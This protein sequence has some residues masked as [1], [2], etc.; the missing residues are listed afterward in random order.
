MKKAILSVLIVLF[1]IFSY[2][3]SLTL[4]NP[5][6][7]IDG[8]STD[9]VYI[10]LQIQNTGSGEMSVVAKRYIIHLPQ[11]QQSYFCFSSGCYAPVVSISPDNVYL[12]PSNTDDTFKGYINPKETEGTSV[13]KYC[14]VDQISGSDSVCITLTTNISSSVGIVNNSHKSFIKAYPNPAADQLTVLFNTEKIYSNASIIIRDLSGRIVSEEFV[15]SA[16]GLVEINTSGLSNGLYFA[17]LSIDGQA[18]ASEK[19]II[20]K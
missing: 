13:I 3:Q 11:G 19:I 15:H 2:A 16:E 18:L 12:E 8:N 1:G 9:E 5:I 6:E 10:N 4:V 14:F 7:S 17:N 20:S